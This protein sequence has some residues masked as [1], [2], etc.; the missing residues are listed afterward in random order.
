MEESDW[1][2][3]FI[4]HL[5]KLRDREDRQALA[6][7]RRGA[8]GQPRSTFEMFPLVVPWVP[9]ARR[10]EDGAL[11]VAALFALH[12][13]PGGVGTLGRAFA[14]IPKKTESTDRRF[15]A[16][17]NCHREDLPVQLRQAISLLR[18]GEVSVDWRRLLG[19]VL[20]WDHESRYVQ[21]GWARDFWQPVDV[22]SQDENVAEE[23]SGL[24]Q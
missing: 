15:V 5:E 2:D 22:V 18:S 23:S 16:L 20:G 8:S 1:R 3:K 13:Q 21:R 14:S 4:A 24:E 19:D 9:K 6:I 10:L 12:P 7:L 17:L 11:L